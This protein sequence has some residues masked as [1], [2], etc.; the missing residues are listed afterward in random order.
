MKKLNATKNCL[1]NIHPLRFRV[2]LLENIFSM[3]FLTN[4]EVRQ[5]VGVYSDSGEEGAIDSRALS[6]SASHGS[7]NSSIITHIK[8]DVAVEDASHFFSI[9]DENVMLWSNKTSSANTSV[10]TVLSSS[11]LQLRD[12]LLSSVK[13]ASAKE[14]QSQGESPM[15]SRVELKYMPPTVVNQ[16]RKA[17]GNASVTSNASTNS[18][19][20]IGFL[21]NEYI[22]RDVLHTIKDCLVELNA[23]K[24][25]LMN[26]SDDSSNEASVIGI[27]ERRQMELSLNK[28]ITSDV[29]EEKLQQRISKLQQCVSEATWRFQL[30]SH[31]W[32][33][34]EQGDIIVDLKKVEETEDDWGKFV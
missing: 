2:E 4:E 28:C 26:N 27:A 11:T 17:S 32:L 30:A 31:D 10:E 16:R 19:H 6:R 13:S 24:F 23:T 25:K 22:V 18:V 21:V 5:D 20:K 15:V 1:S 7:T 34:S 9:S 12:P 14:T 33:P 29:C 8:E 3:L